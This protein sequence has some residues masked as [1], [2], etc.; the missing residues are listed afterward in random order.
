MGSNNM[1]KVIA[2][3][4]IYIS[5]INRSLKTIK[6]EV[7]LSGLMLGIDQPLN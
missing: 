5:N 4:N 6:S 2:Q 1:D 7:I 3:S